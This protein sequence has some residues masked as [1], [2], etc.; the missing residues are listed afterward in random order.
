M[1]K[2]PHQRAVFLVGFMG[3]GKTVVGRAVAKQ[4][5]WLFIDLD[6]QIEKLAGRSIAKI[7][8]TSGEAEFRRLEA[9]KLADLLQE[10]RKG[11]PAVVA[12]GGGAFVERANAEKLREAGMAVIFLDAPLEELV[13]RCHEQSEQPRPLLESDAD[14]LNVLYAERRPLYL[15]AET[16]VQTSGK[17]VAEVADEV[18]RWVQ[19]R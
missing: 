13:R 12:L 9:E 16:T 6:E 8:K 7:F 18:E 19:S 4:L 3:A 5:G 2:A 15:G 1:S 14:A 11:K 17:S 10:L